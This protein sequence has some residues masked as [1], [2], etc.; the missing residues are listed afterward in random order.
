MIINSKNSETPSILEKCDNA[1]WNAEEGA[2]K[3]NA[4]IVIDVKCPIKMKKIEIIN[5]AK[6]FSTKDFSVFGSH[7]STGPWSWLYTGEIVEHSTEVKSLSF[8]LKFLS[9]FK[10]D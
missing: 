8:A 6:E 7:N 10:I 4:M 1:Q 9:Y 3:E 2:V 5:G